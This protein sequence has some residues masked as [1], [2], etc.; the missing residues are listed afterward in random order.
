[1]ELPAAAVPDHH[2]RAADVTHV[3][4][5]YG[6]DLLSL[7]RTRVLA[8]FGM[9]LT[10]EE[11]PEEPSARLELSAALWTAQVHETGE[12]MR[13]GDERRRVHLVQASGERRIEIL[14]HLLPTE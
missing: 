14:E 3:L 11:R 9:I 4:R 5:H 6:L 1:E 2:R 8:R 12:M 7:E 10:G 13:R